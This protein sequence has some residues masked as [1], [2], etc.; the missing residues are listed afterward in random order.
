L[1]EKIQ[2]KEDDS[3][4]KSSEENTQIIINEVSSE[5]NEKGENH[6]KLNNKKYINS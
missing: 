2:I 4:E 3:N 5:K 6:P 1:S